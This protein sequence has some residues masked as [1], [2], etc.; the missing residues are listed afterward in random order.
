M[1]GVVSWSSQ[2][3]FHMHIDKTECR[4]NHQKLDILLQEEKKDGL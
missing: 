4:V 1:T 3:T 2:N